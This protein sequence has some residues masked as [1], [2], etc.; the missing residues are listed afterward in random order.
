MDESPQAPSRLLE[1]RG[2]GGRCCG[3]FRGATARIRRGPGNPP[4]SGNCP[5][6]VR[7]LAGRHLEGNARD[8]GSVNKGHEA[9]MPSEYMKIV[10]EISGIFTFRMRH[11]YRFLH[12]KRN[13]LEYCHPPTGKKWAW[14]PTVME[15]AGSIGSKFQTQPSV[16]M[17]LFLDVPRAKEFLQCCENGD[18][19]IRKNDAEGNLEWW[20]WNVSLHRMD[21]SNVVTLLVG[22]SEWVQFREQPDIYTWPTI[23]SRIRVQRRG[24]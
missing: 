21:N 19:L 3:T 23:Y 14:V 4:A 11:R 9:Q 1:R 10:G 6:G 12:A 20:G 13:R 8:G 22:S 24:R 16:R 5:S 7:D 17:Q 15:P 18:V 2:A